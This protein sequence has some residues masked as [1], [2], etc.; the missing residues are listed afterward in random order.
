MFLLLNLSSSTRSKPSQVNCQLS[1]LVTRAHSEHSV[2]SRCGE[3]S[4]IKGKADGGAV[5]SVVL[6]F[7]EDTLRLRRRVHHSDMEGLL[8]VGQG[9]LNGPG[10][11]VQLRRV[12]PFLRGLLV[13]EV[14]IDELELLGRLL[15]VSHRGVCLICGSPT[16]PEALEV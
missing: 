11:V 10:Q 16:V 14:D 6:Q 3:G 9:R 1:R 7:H 2:S 12:T 8:I 13:A 5:G 15:L 4:C